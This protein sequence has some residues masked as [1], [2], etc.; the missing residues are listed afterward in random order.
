MICRFKDFDE[1]DFYA[2]ATALDPRYKQYFFNRE[3][4]FPRVKKV[5]S[6]KMEIGE[7]RCKKK[8]KTN[9]PPVY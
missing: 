4:T 5:L 9:P 8:Q 3:E 6:T 1:K 7:K 2:I